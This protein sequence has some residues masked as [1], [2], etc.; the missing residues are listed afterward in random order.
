MRTQGIPLSDFSSLFPVPLKAFGSLSPPVCYSLEPLCLCTSRKALPPT[1]R[2]LGQLYLLHEKA[3]RPGLPPPVRIPPA[4]QAGSLLEVLERVDG[5]LTFELD[6]GS[7]P[8]PR[9]WNV[10]LPAS[11]SQS[12]FEG[13][14]LE[15]A[16]CG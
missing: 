4:L 14:R 5:Q 7:T 11:R 15:G 8:H 13:H 10:V 2:L 6:P 12:H 1:G 16:L 3:P 9:P